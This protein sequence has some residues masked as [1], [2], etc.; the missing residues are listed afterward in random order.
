M[1][2]VQF[3]VG[4]GLY[5]L[6]DNVDWCGIFQWTFRDGHMVKVFPCQHSWHVVGSDTKW[7][8][9]VCSF[10]SPACVPRVVS[11]HRLILS[12]PRGLSVDHINGNTLDNR[13]CNLRFATNA[14]NLRNMR[15]RGGSSKYKGVYLLRPGV[16]RAHI[17]CNYK[18]QNLGNYRNEQD[19][20]RAYNARAVEVFGQYARL[21][22]VP[23]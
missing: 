16:W 22:E 17:M 20:A 6:I 11:L 8:Y 15:I 12:A 7:L 1:K 14:E 4:H 23:Q 5:A 10:N 21:N 3:N 9:A 13:R 18:K 2:A 19:A